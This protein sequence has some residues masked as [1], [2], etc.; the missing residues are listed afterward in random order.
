MA[1]Y[2]FPAPWLNGHPIDAPNKIN[3][4]TWYSETDGYYPDATGYDSRNSVLSLFR[5]QGTILYDDEFHSETTANYDDLQ[6]I[7]RIGR[8]FRAIDMIGKYKAACKDGA[9][10]SNSARVDFTTVWRDNEGNVLPDETMHNLKHFE[11][12]LKKKS[13]DNSPVKAF[14]T[15]QEIQRSI[16]YSARTS[17]NNLRQ[18]CSNVV[19]NRTLP[20]LDHTKKYINPFMFASEK[21][22]QNHLQ[23]MAKSLSKDAQKPSRALNPKSTEF[24]LSP[25]S[26]DL[27][28][29]AQKLSTSLGTESTLSS[30]APEA[31]ETELTAAGIVA[32][33][34]VETNGGERDHEDWSS[35]E[36]FI[37]TFIRPKQPW[38]QPQLSGAGY[39]AREPEQ[40]T[41]TAPTHQAIVTKGP[42][43]NNVNSKGNQ[44]QQTEHRGDGEIG[45]SL[46]QPPV[47]GTMRYGGCQ[48]DHQESEAR[49]RSKI[50]GSEEDLDVH[51]RDRIHDW[52]GGIVAPATRE[53]EE[54]LTWPEMKVLIVNGLW[55]YWLL[56]SKNRKFV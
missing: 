13:P 42:Q 23:N 21:H 44:R 45:I 32:E 56:A 34:W 26:S 18:N 5:F 1:S 11:H 54:L 22:L 48:E 39:V 51:K 2:A 41:E 10:L 29:P 47:Y 53:P 31:T 28:L 36:S 52:L 9:D 6:T 35:D 16:W 19:N 3:M 8:V 25:K 40:V 27:L 55:D 12:E 7:G 33:E 14:W 4:I 43:N 15:C 20:G 46:S 50:R 49:R 24:I 38:S 37:P 30:E 17:N